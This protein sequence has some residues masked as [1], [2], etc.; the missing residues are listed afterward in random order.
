M[1]KNAGY[2]AQS[3]DLHPNKGHFG[4]AN[5]VTTNAEQYIPPYA[6]S[7]TSVSVTTWGLLWRQPRV[8]AIESFK[9]QYTGHAGNVGGQ[10]MTAKLYYLRS[11]S[12]TLIPGA[13]SDAMATTAGVKTATVTLDT[14]FQPADGDV[15]LASLTPS[16]GLSNA[17]EGVMVALG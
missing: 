4:A 16:A 17:L 2:V 7:V 3:T 13:T 8:T 11:G 15:I 12:A 10:T 1:T 5:S 6:G 14:P 9:V